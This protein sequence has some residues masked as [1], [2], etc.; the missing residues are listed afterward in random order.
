MQAKISAFFKPSVQNDPEPAI[1]SEDDI[2]PV[3]QEILVT[4]RRRIPNSN[5]M[6][7][8]DNAYE[9]DNGRQEQADC[10]DYKLK[11]QEVC[12]A[13]LASS[14][15]KPSSTNRALNRKRSYAQYHLELGQSDFLLHTCSICGL[16]YSRGDEEDEKVHKAFHMNYYRGIQF[17]GWRNERVVPTSS[18]NGDRI[19]LVLDGDPPAHR[20]KVAEVVK[21]MEWELSLSDEWLLHNSSS[22]KVFLF[23]SK[24]RIIGCLV[25]EPIR[26]AYRV[27]SCPAAC[28]SLDVKNRK[29]KSDPTPLQFGSVIFQ[30]EITRKLSS[31]STE[32]IDMNERGAVLCEENAVSASCG[33]RAIWV[34]PSSRRKR[35]ATQLLDAM[36][37]NF[38]KGQVL[39]PSQ[40]AFSQPTSSGNA[41]ASSYSGTRSFLVYLTA[42][43]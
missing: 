26:T 5:S 28:K 1:L 19:I 2:P 31:A 35:V 42:T 20:H 23:I 10:S 41:L 30:R 6:R 12:C 38:Y 17:K 9:L 13:D 3:K 36:R 8:D 32:I 43:S 24:Q 16:K 34:A 4:Y 14:L 25:A 33:I 18:G 7:K 21:I 27:V 15:V 11:D 39:E 37:K 40:C 29:I 22:C